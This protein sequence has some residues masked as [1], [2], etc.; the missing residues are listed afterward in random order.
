[1]NSNL[2]FQRGTEILRWAFPDL[3]M[4]CVSLLG[5]GW[6]S[7]ALLVNDNFV[8]RI[9]QRPAVARQML[10]EIQVLEA[11]RSWVSVEIPKIEWIGPAYESFPVTAVGYRKL[12]GQSLSSLPS[13]ADSNS[14]RERVGQFLMELHGIPNSVLR[15][16]SV[17]WF[18]WTGDADLP[19]PSSWKEGLEGFFQRTVESIVPLLTQPTGQKAIRTFSNFLSEPAHFEFEPVLLHG[20]LA[21]EHILVDTVH[22]AIG[23]IDFGDC[24]L[25]DAAYD[26]W[27]ELVPFYCKGADN[28]R[29][30]GVNHK[31]D[32]RLDT[33]FC[34]RQQF[35]RKLAPLHD[36]LYGEMTDNAVLV[37][38]GID[39]IEEVFAK[40][41]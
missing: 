30:A 10:K 4:G 1:M 15:G 11:V 2:S 24:G 23:I 38:R 20:D 32:S 25:G 22:D 7:L 36:V 21:P 40:G 33:S 9:P 16:I 13:L 8:F 37:E 31:L 39:R 17:P 27:P 3:P 28:R 14:V 35:Y 18:R 26:V 29:N 19:Y 34:D 12:T 41:D 6:D 5:E